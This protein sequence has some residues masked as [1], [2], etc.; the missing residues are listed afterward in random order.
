[1]PP[2]KKTRHSGNTSCFGPPCPLPDVGSL[3]TL[4]DVLAAVEFGK[5]NSQDENSVKTTEKK[6]REK[7]LEANPR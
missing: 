4:R 6:V 1:M 5:I 2:R 7:F 3:Y